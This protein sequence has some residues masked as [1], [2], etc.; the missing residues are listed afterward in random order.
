V[1]NTALALESLARFQV[2][3]AATYSG[4]FHPTAEGHAAI[5]DSV[6]ERARAVLKKYGQQSAAA[7]QP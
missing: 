2:L 7:V 5:A 1:T 3:V 6:A 4:A